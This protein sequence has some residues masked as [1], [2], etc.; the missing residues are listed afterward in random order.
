MRNYCPDARLGNNFYIYSSHFLLCDLIC[1]LVTGIYSGITLMLHNLITEPEIVKRFFGFVL[2]TFNIKGL[3]L[4]MVCFTGLIWIKSSWIQLEKLPTLTNGSV[5]RFG[6]NA[7]PTW[8]RDD[9]FQMQFWG[10]SHDQLVWS[11]YSIFST[12]S[13]SKF[14]LVIMINLVTHR[15]AKTKK[16]CSHPLASAHQQTNIEKALQTDANEACLSNVLFQPWPMW[17]LMS[18]FWYQLWAEFHHQCPV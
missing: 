6:V 17:C 10:L 16:L 14:H 5:S 2:F 3:F 8:F 11:A 18:V 7:F 9:K 1:L 13:A 12:I 15:L 4:A